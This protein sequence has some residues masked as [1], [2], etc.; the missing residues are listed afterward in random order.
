MILFELLATQWWQNRQNRSSPLPACDDGP[1]DAVPSGPNCFNSIDAHRTFRPIRLLPCLGEQAFAI[2]NE[3]DRPVSP[4]KSTANKTSDA[5]RR[6]VRPRI[7]GRK[8]WALLLAVSLSSTGCASMSGKS[9]WPFAKADATGQ[10]SSFASTLSGAGKSVVGQFQSMGTAVKSAAG[11]A[12]TAVT[13]PFSSTA[14]SDDPT[15]LTSKATIGPEVWVAN[16]QLNETRGEFTKALD[17][18]TKALELEPTNLAA[19][20][21]TARL[22]DR[23]GDAP[24]AAEFFQKAIAVKPDDASLYNEL[25]LA[26][27]KAGNTAE[28]ESNIQKAI[29]LDPSNSRYRNNLASIL[30][31]GGRSDE[32]V[33]QLE[34]VF[35]PAVA[36][37]NVAYLHASKQNLAAAQQHLQL[38]LQIDPN[39]K[40]ARDLMNRLGGSST[41][42]AASNAYNMAGSVMQAMQGGAT[43]GH[44]PSSTTTTPNYPSVNYAN[45]TSSVMPSGTATGQPTAPQILR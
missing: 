10:T 5:Y 20:L 3:K 32:A 25:G 22:Y 2:R 9:L 13:A 11:K 43:A 17:N 33:R 37:Y 26:K 29:A 21:S 24:K 38:A 40:E 8:R 31:D 1:K 4:A 27:A 39:L 14:K 18:Y 42:Q 34:Q 35:A 44:V 7:F 41:V 19:L 28:A 36:N 6:V 15:S 16:G 23:Q 30:V 12:K 45:G